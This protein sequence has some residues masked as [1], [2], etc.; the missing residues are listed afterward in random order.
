M[1][2]QESGLKQ[3]GSNIFAWVYFII[4]VFLATVRMDLCA[5][6]FQCQQELVEIHFSI[7]LYGD[8]MRD[9]SSRVP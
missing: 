2:T 8:L 7:H 9:D 4:Y 5:H 6:S 1:G 3:L